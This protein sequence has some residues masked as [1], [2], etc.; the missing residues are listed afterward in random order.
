MSQEVCVEGFPPSITE[1][2]LR[3]LFSACGTVLSVDMAMGVDGRPLGFATVE[4]AAPE[5]AHRAIQTL[6]HVKVDG[7]TLLVFSADSHISQA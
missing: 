2:E 6:H 4:M 3:H 1:D 7:C 5:L